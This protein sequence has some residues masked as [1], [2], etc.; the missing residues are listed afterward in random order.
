V[1]QAKEAQVIGNQLLRCGTSV[2]ANYRAACQARSKAEFI[3]KIGIVAEEADET[4][5]WIELLSENYEERTSRTVTQGGT[6]VDRYF[7][8]VTTDGKAKIAIGLQIDTS[9]NLGNFGN[10]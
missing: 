8:C 2:G 5:F 7:F 6:R 9:G 10:S 1:P 3:A 4:V